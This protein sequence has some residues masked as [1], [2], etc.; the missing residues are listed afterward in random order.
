MEN[1]DYLRDY[2]KSVGLTAKFH[3]DWKTSSRFTGSRGIEIRDWLDD[4]PEI[5][6]WIAIDDST[7]FAQDQ[8]PN[9]ILTT[10]QNGILFEHYEKAV[11]I[12]GIIK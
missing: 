4:H 9:L 7:S 12:L 8:L 5:T 6:N 3:N 2:L 11:K 10:S 1:I